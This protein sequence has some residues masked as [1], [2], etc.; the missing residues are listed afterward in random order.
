MKLGLGTAQ[1]GMDYGVANRNGQTSMAEAREILWAAELNG[2]SVID[3]AAVYGD[4]E[5]VLG[6]LLPKQHQHTFRIITKLPGLL[7]QD[8]SGISSNEVVN[9]LMESLLRLRQE[10]VYGVILHRAED[11]L[12]VYG[13]EVMKG[14][15][16][17]KRLGLASKIGI[18]VYAE[19]RVEELISRYPIDLIQVPVNLFD[20]RLVQN[21]LLSRCKSL[22]IE[23]HAR[24][25]FL[26]GLLC[27]DPL[28]LPAYF[29]P[30]TEQI[31]R[32]HS[33]VKEKGMSPVEAAMSYV[34][35]L[36]VIDTFVCGVN[37]QE[38]LLQL[39]ALASKSS[40][41]FDYS[42]FASSEPS[43]LNPSLW[44]IS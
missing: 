37:R 10:G 44:K 33:F 1:L 27:M 15:Q 40:H 8:G 20:Q 34:N 5:R 41:G 43:L 23:V 24:S 25:V 22:G 35:D 28:E 29:R 11:L 42:D 17:C 26:Q 14:L 31:L 36:P 19:D 30:H 13:D 21:G 32:F 2:I 3:T 39:I 16:K 12:S 9:R 18:S 7:P 4:S 6:M 38:Q